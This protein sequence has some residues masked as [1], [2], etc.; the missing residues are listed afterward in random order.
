MSLATR[1]QERGSSGEPE[2]LRATLGEHLD[3]LRTRVLRVLGCLV[4]ASTLGWF[5]TRPLYDFLTDVYR[6]NLPKGLDY[7]EPFRSVAEPFL[8]KLKLAFYIGLTVTAPYLVLQLWGF[9]APGLRPHERKPI[10]FLA[11]FSLVLFAV[12]CWAGWATLPQAFVWFAGFFGEFPSTSLYQEPGT[13]VFFIVKMVLAFG[14]GF[15][16]PVVTFF[17]AKVGILSTETLFRH[18]RQAT[19]AIFALAAI[20]TPSGDPVTMVAMAA[21]LTLLFFASIMAVKFTSRKSLRDPVLNDLD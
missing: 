20:L 16:L 17:L 9:I 4:V 10:K 21:P 14:L 18:W 6:A 1:D 5:V 13:M 3:E 2:E 7:A 15:Q 11:P 19:V 12:G 8:L